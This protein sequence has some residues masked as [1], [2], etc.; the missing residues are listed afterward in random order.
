M[1]VFV[2]FFIAVVFVCLVGGFVLAFGLFVCCSLVLFVLFFLKRTSV[3]AL[4]Y[5][6]YIMVFSKTTNGQMQCNYDHDAAEGSR[7]CMAT[8]SHTGYCMYTVVC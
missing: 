3:I 5:N 1:D 2:G 6:F 8:S 7:S 4:I